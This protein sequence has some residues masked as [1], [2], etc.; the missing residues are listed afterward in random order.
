MVAVV[1]EVKGEEDVEGLAIQWVEIEVIRGDLEHVFVELVGWFEVGRVDETAAQPAFFEGDPTIAALF[2]VFFQ[3]IF[4]A[5]PTIEV[6]HL[7]KRLLQPVEVVKDR[8][9]AGGEVHLRV[10]VDVDPEIITQR[11]IGIH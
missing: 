5:L 7:G 2:A 9:P 11:A 4:P 1:H 6:G 10:E 3:N 8:L